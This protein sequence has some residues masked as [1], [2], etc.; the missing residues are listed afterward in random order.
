MDSDQRRLLA[1]MPLHAITSTYGEEGLRERFA[2]EI[3][4]WPDAD[5]ARLERALDLATRLHAGDRRDR[6]PYLNHLLRV[7]I[8]IISHYGVHD[9]DV[10]CA[11]LLH[12][13]VEDH[14]DELA[15]GGLGGRAVPPIAGGSPGGSSPRGEQ[16]PRWRYWRR[17]SGRGWRS[18][19][20]R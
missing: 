13:A 15:Q 12:D 14:P 20:R 5:R 18:W 3:A 19:S 11:A 7:A 4:S 16:R 17:S 1:T 8:R 2:L 10:I 9:P 6:E